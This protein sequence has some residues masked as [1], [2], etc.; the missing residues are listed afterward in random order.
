MITTQNRTSK[1]MI[2]ETLKVVLEFLRLAPRYIAAI[3]V[4]TGFLLFSSKAI[5]SK[6]GIWDFSQ[7]NRS[8]IGIAFVGSSALFLIG[9]LIDIFKWIGKCMRR[10]RISRHI[11]DRL[12]NLTEGEKQI[13]RYYLANQTRANTL[14]YDD[15]VVQ[16]LAAEGIIYRS[17]TMGSLLEGFSYN[18]SDI[19]WDYLHLHPNLLMGPT[20]TYRTDK[21][22][23]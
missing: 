3:T 21:L 15:G 5:L 22:D 18:I 16:E 8:W 7:N 17:T 23:W 13:L 20:N 1:N 9:L 11:I 6:I 10:R 2:A 4:F 14:R 19:A 12:H